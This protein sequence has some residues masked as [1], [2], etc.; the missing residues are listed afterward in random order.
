MCNS[1]MACGLGETCDPY[2]YTC[3]LSP[4]NRGLTRGHISEVSLTINADGVPV[5]NQAGKKFKII[6]KRILLYNKTKI[7]KSREE[8]S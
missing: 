2:T 8:V 6:I 5:V 4:E 1:R 7:L 3:I